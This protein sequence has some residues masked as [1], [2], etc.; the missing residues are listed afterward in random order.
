M[1]APRVFPRP[2][3]SLGVV[4][5]V[6]GGDEPCAAGGGY[7]KA[8]NA[9]RSNKSSTGAAAPR[10]LLRVPQVGIQSGSAKLNP[11]TRA[12]STYRVDG[13]GKRGSAGVLRGGTPP[14]MKPQ[15]RYGRAVAS[16]HHGSPSIIVAPRRMPPRKPHN[17]PLLGKGDRLRW[18]RRSTLFRCCPP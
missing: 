14:A 15:S 16:R 17:L 4:G 6:R 13:G 7:S 3:N 2:L 11:E 9:P 18:M 1:S 12:P 10:R 5:G 8:R